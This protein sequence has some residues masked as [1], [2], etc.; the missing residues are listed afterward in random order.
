MFKYYIIFYISIF[1]KRAVLTKSRPVL[2]RG[3]RLTGNAAA[4]VHGIVLLDN[5]VYRPYATISCCIR[6]SR[7]RISVH[8]SEAFAVAAAAAA[9]DYWSDAECRHDMRPAV[10]LPSVSAVDAKPGLMKIFYSPQ[11][12]KMSFIAF[13]S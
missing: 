7:R 11:L 12:A 10:Q 6:P 13:Q 9:A 8:C 2:S 1:C 4:T 3:G 5:D